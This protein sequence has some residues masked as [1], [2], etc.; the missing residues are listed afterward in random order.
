MR[1]AYHSD[2]PES[3]PSPPGAAGAPAGS[4]APRPTPLLP[5]HQKLG[6]SLTGFAGWLMPLRYQSEPA[7]H[8]A[9]RGAAGLFALPHM[10]EIAVSGPGAAAPLDPAVVGQLSALA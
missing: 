9:V 7:E 1:P 2:V 8:L 5:I 6:A 3:P 4:A 10:G